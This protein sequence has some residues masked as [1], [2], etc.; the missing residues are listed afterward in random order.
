[1]YDD[2]EDT[3]EEPDVDDIEVNAEVGNT[4]H[5]KKKFSSF[6]SPAG[7]SLQNSPWAGIMTSQLNYSCPGGVWLVTSRLETGNS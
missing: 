4:I 1:M 5:R 6:V 3:D 7:K 2:V